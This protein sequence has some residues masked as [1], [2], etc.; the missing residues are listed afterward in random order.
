MLN[1]ALLAI[2]PLP[3]VVGILLLLVTLYRH[4]LPPSKN[5]AVEKVAA[6][7]V[8][9]TLQLPQWISPRIAYIGHVLGYVQDG[10]GYFAALCSATSLPIF[11]IRMA[12]VKLSVVKPE[13]TRDLPKVRNL[14]LAPLVLQLFKR[15]LGL[16]EFSCSLLREEDEMSK[17]FAPEISRLF[18]EEFIPNKNLRKYVEEIDGYVQHEVMA[19]EDE[20]KI[21]IEEWI[22]NTLVGAL[23]K[24]LWGGDNGPF[25]DPEFVTHLRTF[26]MNMKKLNAPFDFMIDEKLLA[27]R[28][29]VRER[30]EEFSFEE[31]AEKCVRGSAD[32]V[33]ESFLGRVR[34]LCLTHGAAAERWTDYQ[35]L[36]IAGLGPNVMAASTWMFHHLLAEPELMVEVRKELDEFLPGRFLK[37]DRSLDELQRRKLRVYGVFGTL[38]PGRYL[39][40]HMAMALTVRLLLAF[41]MTRVDGSQTPPHESKDTVAGLATPAVDVEVEMRRR[42]SDCDGVKIRF[43]SGRQA[44]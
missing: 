39:A 44:F 14:S 22:F 2:G 31:Y 41:D 12:A 3:V 20:Q 25:G 7:T 8:T 33:E 4:R 19:I 36:L 29:F 35:L 27:S 32:A 24:S 30:L 15:S 42:D 34:A 37:E 28:R 43:K 26:L 6:D 40:V 18:R 11:T 13:L 23:G 10:H 16:G 5:A 21:F 17:K 38:C 9:K 1:E